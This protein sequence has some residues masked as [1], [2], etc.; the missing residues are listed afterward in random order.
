MILLTG[1]SG[2]LGQAVL[3][4]L[5]KGDT[6]VVTAGRSTLPGADF[7][8]LDLSEPG[9]FRQ[10]LTGADVVIHCA[11]IAHNKGDAQSYEQVNVR[12]T[13]ALA[14]AAIA[15]GVR[16]FIF[17]SSLNVM[18]PDYPDPRAQ[19]ARLPRP[20]SLYAASKWRCEQNLEHLLAYSDCRLTIVRPGL[21]YDREL[22]ANL[23]VL[24]R[25]ARWIPFKL[26]DTG[27]R[28]MIARP[29]LARLLA[30]LS[31]RTASRLDHISPTERWAAVDGEVY[32][33]RRM[34]EALG[35]RALVPLPIP[36]WQLVALGKDLF[37]GQP[38]G[39][40]WGNLAGRYWRCSK[41]A[42]TA[43]DD[44][45]PEWTLESLWDSPA[46]GERA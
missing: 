28:C 1:A 8:P 22:T 23:A 42:L 5:L 3:A 46:E 39:T 13:M 45:C 17:V 25:M 32:S 11:G 21:I 37:S 16:H 20:G 43:C 38:L 10:A 41:D 31:T 44:W 19:A 9:G 40:V 24:R 14:D 27:H 15:A 6:P 18:D 12:A 4:E 2:Y 7:R 29:D 33:A 26:P 34:S 35:V 30:V 36:I